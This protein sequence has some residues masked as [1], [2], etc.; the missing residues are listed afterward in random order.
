M[1]GADRLSFLGARYPRNFRLRTVIL[2]PL[3][4]IDCQQT[5][6]A[7]TL[8]VVEQGDLEIECRS[9]ARAC[10]PEGAIVVFAGLALRR[11]RNSSS[12]PLVLT[13]LS[14]I[15]SAD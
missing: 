10:F 5:D 7:D 13:A 3:D 6:W 8:V 9:G 4:A 1:D 12:R 11:L 14:R 2:Q 15:R